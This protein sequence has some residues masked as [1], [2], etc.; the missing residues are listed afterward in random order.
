MPQTSIIDDRNAA[1]DAC[2]MIKLSKPTH[3]TSTGS[4]PVAITRRTSVRERVRTGVAPFD[5]VAAMVGEF[6]FAPFDRG[7]LADHTP[8]CRVCPTE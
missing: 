4:V 2:V 7:S 5:F 3:P 6:M 8:G 1:L